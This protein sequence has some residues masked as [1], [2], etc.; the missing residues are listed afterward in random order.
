MPPRVAVTLKACNMGMGC[1]A[2]NPLWSLRCASQTIG[3]TSLNKLH[4]PESGA[5]RVSCSFSTPCARPSATQ[6]PSHTEYLGL[7]LRKHS[8]E[9]RVSERLALNGCAVDG[10]QPPTGVPTH[11]HR[12]SAAGRSACRRT[13]A[14]RPAGRL[15]HPRPSA[16]GPT[17]LRCK[18]GRPPRPAPPA[19]SQCLRPG[20]AP[21]HNK[22][23][24]PGGSTRTVV[25][26][27]AFMTAWSHT[28]T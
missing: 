2:T 4:V 20:S 26:S 1:V 5:Q 14:S 25:L 28:S 24:R 15:H 8:G 23:Q 3:F 11:A 7:A 22:R 16:R 6:R 27:G 19:H 10:Q 9:V 13:R 18:G 17:V 12:K 21:P